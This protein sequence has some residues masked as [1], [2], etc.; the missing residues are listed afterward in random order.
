MAHISATTSSQVQEFLNKN[1]GI[2][3]VDCYATWCGPCK[4]IGPLVDQL[5]KE[6]KVPVI[7]IDVDLSQELS[8][9]YEIQCMPTFLL[10]KGQWNNIIR[11][12]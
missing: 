5:N 4:L 11:R 2:A 6:K 12:F 3:V 8:V 10:I 9:S 1:G 7:K